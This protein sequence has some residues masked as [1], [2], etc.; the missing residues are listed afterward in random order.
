MTVKYF[1]TSNDGWK[2]IVSVDSLSTASLNIGSIPQHYSELVLVVTNVTAVGWPIALTVNNISS[3]S[4]DYIQMDHTGTTAT[5][6]AIGGDTA[7]SITNSTTPND[8]AVIRF[9]AYSDANTGVRPIESLF[10]S[11][12]YNH[13]TVITKGTCRSLTSAITSVG[14]NAGGGT[15]SANN[16]TLYGVV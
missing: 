2:K 6:T 12:S 14:L 13:G 16:I 15:F 7:F 8:R 1:G 9:V 5:T 3:A 4:Y 11:T 10:N